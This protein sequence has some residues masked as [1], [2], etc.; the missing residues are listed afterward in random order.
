MGKKKQASAAEGE[1]ETKGGSK[2]R[3]LF[4]G[5]AVVALAAGGYVFTSGGGSADAAAG[6]PVEEP[7]PVPGDVVS[8]QPITL[9]LADGR[10]LKVALALQLVEGVAAPAAG[11]VDG[12][13]APAL[14]EAISLLGSLSY[15]DLVAPGGRDA[16]KASLSERIG[17][18]YEGDVMD[19]YFTELVMQ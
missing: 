5:A 11:D 8:L 14:D 7:A 10:F 13:A 2:K 17:A 3:L 12:F 4:I 9:N 15:A 6:E 19:V 1:E 16:A 18:R